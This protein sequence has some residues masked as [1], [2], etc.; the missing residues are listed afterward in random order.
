MY[1]KNDSERLDTV[2]ALVEAAKAAPHRKELELQ[3]AQA[4]IDQMKDQ[5]MKSKAQKAVNAAS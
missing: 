3:Q 1:H 4:I 2:L 5:S